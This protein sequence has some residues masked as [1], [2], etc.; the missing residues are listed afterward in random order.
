MSRLL[1]WVTLAIVDVLVESLS[2][3]A[4][5]TWY[6]S[7]APCCPENANY[8]PNAD[9][10]ECVQYS[11]CDYSG[12]FWA[13]GHKSFNYVQTNNLVAFYDSSDKNGN[14]F[15]TNYGGKEIILMKNG[16]TFK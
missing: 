15:I 8:D 6:I 13:I 5:L 7:Y 1:L 14:N 4:Q 11:A 12:D 2:G 9:T 16:I 10:T 3:T